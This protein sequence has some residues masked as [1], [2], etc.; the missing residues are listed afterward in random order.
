MFD[1]GANAA[2]SRERAAP[3]ALGFERVR[4][5]VAPARAEAAPEG[6]PVERQPQQLEVAQRAKQGL[7]VVALAAERRQPCRCGRDVA[8]RHAK[9]REHRIRTD[10]DTNRG[11]AGEQRRHRF[12]EADGA[13]DLVRPVVGHRHRRGLYGARGIAVNRNRGRAQRHRREEFLELRCRAGH[14]RGMER[15]RD[16]ERHTLETAGAELLAERLDGCRIAGNDGLLWTVVRRDRRRLACGAS[17]SLIVVAIACHRR[18]ASG[19]RGLHQPRA[20]ADDPYGVF[21]REHAREASGDELAD[22]VAEQNVGLQAE[23]LEQPRKRI[24]TQKSDVC[25]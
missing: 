21:D 15:T 11:P 12:F 2:G 13:Q 6:G 22:A 4:R 7:P 17:S 25:V 14:Q 18:H 3:V 16:G 19:R 10:L 1:G 24:S 8:E 9:R 5:R 20:F 23:C